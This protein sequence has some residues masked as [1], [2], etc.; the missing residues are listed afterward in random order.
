MA[1]ADQIP[2]DGEKRSMHP[3]KCRETFEEA[4]VRRGFGRRELW[5]LDEADCSIDVSLRSKSRWV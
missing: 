4:F 3:I 1:H 5:A 2:A